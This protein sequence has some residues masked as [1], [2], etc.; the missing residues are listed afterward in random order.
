MIL[1][2]TRLPLILEL[3]KDGYAVVNENDSKN[4]K[5][6]WLKVTE[7]HWTWQQQTIIRMTLHRDKTSANLAEESLKFGSPSL[8]RRHNFVK[9]IFRH[10]ICILISS[11]VV[12][13]I[14]WE[15]LYILLSVADLTM[16]FSQW[17]FLTPSTELTLRTYR[18]NRWVHEYLFSCRLS[19]SHRNRI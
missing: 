17:L 8:I 6:G 11:A 5:K 12:S 10:P 13:V 3:F 7:H 15:L 16:S 9:P 4:E 1:E 18:L 14:T 2:C 19:P